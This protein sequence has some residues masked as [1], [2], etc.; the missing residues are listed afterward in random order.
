MYGYIYIYDKINL[1]ISLYDEC[2]LSLGQ[3][4]N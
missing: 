4:T 3:D 2:C 1:Q